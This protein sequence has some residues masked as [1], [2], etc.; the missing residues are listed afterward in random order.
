MVNYLQVT[1]LAKH[2]NT[3]S[4]HSFNQS[5]IMRLIKAACFVEQR[6]KLRII[7]KFRDIQS[8]CRYKFHCLTIK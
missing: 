1:S 5:G 6:I 3:E 7:Q 8:N 4:L 2:Q